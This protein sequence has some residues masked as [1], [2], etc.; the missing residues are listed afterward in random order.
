V[1][2]PTPIAVPP[3]PKPKPEIPV[4]PKQIRVSTGVQAAKVIRQVKPAYP[5]LARKARV[6]GTVKLTAVIGRSG[7]VSNLQLISGHPLLVPAA[8]N[9]VSQ[10]VYEPTLLSGEPVEVIT[11]IDVNFTLSQ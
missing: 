8:V 9:A 10:W 2:T 4:V 3:P 11:Q 5:D 7:T 6:Q 1:G